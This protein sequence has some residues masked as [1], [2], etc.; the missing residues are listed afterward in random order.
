M[1]PGGRVCGTEPVLAGRV[2]MFRAGLLGHILPVRLLQMP[3][4]LVP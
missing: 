1:R 4:T 3:V 2:G